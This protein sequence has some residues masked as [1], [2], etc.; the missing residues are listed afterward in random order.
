MAAIRPLEREDLPAVAA[1]IRDNLGWRREIAVLE[2]TL[3]DHPWAP[4]KLPSLVAV[5]DS[6]VIIGSIG[7]QARRVV[8][9]GAEI[10]GIS[11]SHLVVAPQR[12]GGAAGALLVRELLSGEQDVTWTDSGTADVVRIWRTFGGHLDHARSC[13]WMLVLR[14]A[15]WLARI[16]SLRARSDAGL[17]HSVPV[18][19]LPLQAAGRR[20]L[21]RAFSPPSAADVV[22][23]DAS[24]PEITEL[25]P[26]LTK[27]YRLRVDYDAGY[28]SWLFQHLG[29]LGAPVV[30]RLVRRA[31]TPIGW[32]AYIRQPGVSRVIHLSARARDVEA[33][34][35]DLHRYS[36]AQGAALLAGRLE[37][38]LEGPL[39][40]RFAAVGLSQR[41]LAH[42]RD[43]ELRATLA[44]SSSLITEMDLID[45]EWW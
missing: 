38:H 31:G 15:R 20:L 44:S 23:E 10:S 1:L 43:P 34:F 33:V 17:R 30:H 11:V 29:S 21:P 19:A 41:P 32:Y 28:L 9:D 14:P 6:G 24:P 26:T 45:S 36:R 13:N 2:R 7:A 40:R 22:G 42:A 18:T 5:D 3:V 8:F 25:L 16:A 27:S 39:R 35:D 12:R 4:E 37:P